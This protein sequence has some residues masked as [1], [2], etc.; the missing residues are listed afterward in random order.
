MSPSSSL[1]PPIILPLVLVVWPAINAGSAHFLADELQSRFAEPQKAP[2]ALKGIIALG[3][4]HDRIAEAVRLAGRYP[5]AKLIVTGA[6]AADEDYART[7][8]LESAQLLIESHARS[9][10]ENALYS[11]QLLNPVAGEKWLIVTSA[12][13]MPRAIG[14]FR[15][16]GFAVVP[17]PVFDLSNAHATAEHGTWHEVFGL[18]A[19][20]FLGRIDSLFPAPLA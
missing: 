13:H 16:A 18:L 15:E 17:W 4:S 20:W 3:G 14:T 7:H 11:R 1:L 2:T 6:S 5:A 10:F 19:Y 9:T 8:I 12:I